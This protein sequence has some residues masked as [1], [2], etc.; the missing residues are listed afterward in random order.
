[1]LDGNGEQH[2]HHRDTEDTENGHREEHSW[3]LSFKDAMQTV[4]AE[5]GAGTSQR[6]PAALPPLFG[7]I[8]LRNRCASLCPQKNVCFYNIKDLKCQIPE[9]LVVS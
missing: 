5:Y 4:G 2:F 1:M 6:A 9:E 7:G 8:V 3:L